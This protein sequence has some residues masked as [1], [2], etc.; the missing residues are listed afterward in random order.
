MDL[1][2][3]VT[4]SKKIRQKYHQLEE[5]HH[6]RKWELQEDALALSTDVAL[7]NRLIMDKVN[8]WPAKKDKTNNLEYKIGEVVWWLAIISDKSDID[9]NKAVETFLITKK[10][11]FDIE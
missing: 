4:E 3:V 7:I 5:Y 6:N 10:S 8:I 11:D 1:N 9:F 2:E